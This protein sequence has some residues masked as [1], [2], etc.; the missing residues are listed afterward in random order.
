[1]EKYSTRESN[2]RK[3]NQLLVTYFNYTTF[4]RQLWVNTTSCKTFLY[5]HIHMYLAG[6]LKTLPPN[7][8]FVSSSFQSLAITKTKR[9]STTTAFF[10]FSSFLPPYSFFFSVT[11]PLLVQFW[12]LSGPKNLPFDTF[13]LK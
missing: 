13:L 3:S 11:F 2:S 12:S 4:E 9:L 8:P 10:L 7:G 5:V 1:M 6:F